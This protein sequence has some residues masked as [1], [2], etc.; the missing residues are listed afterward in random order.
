MIKQGCV[1]TPQDGEMHMTPRYSAHSE[2]INICP[3][4]LTERGRKVEKV[5][6][7][8]EPKTKKEIPRDWFYGGT[9]A[10]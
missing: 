3:I 8:P 6:V 2:V 4:A 9:S 5:E 1:L 7:E 10:T